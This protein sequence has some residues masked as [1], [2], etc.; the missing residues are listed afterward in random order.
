RVLP[1]SA[2]QA[3]QRLEQLLH[4][5]RL[6]LRQE[7]GEGEGR[8]VFGDVDRGVRD[9]ITKRF[10]AQVRAPIGEIDLR[11]R[12]AGEGR[13]LR[14]GLVRYILET[15]FRFGQLALVGLDGA[16]IIFRDVAFG[17]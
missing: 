12:I 13:V 14:V 16:D 17:G 9:K 4:F 7:P 15:G 11:Q 10:L 8:L 1:D 3:A 2:L 5:G 6:F